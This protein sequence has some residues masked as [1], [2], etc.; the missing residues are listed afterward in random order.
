MAVTATFTNAAVA[1]EILTFTMT[2]V[3]LPRITPTVRG[4]EEVY[5]ELTGKAYA[6][7]ANTNAE[8]ATTLLCCSQNKSVL[9]AQIVETQGFDRAT[10]V[11]LEQLRTAA[12]RLPADY[13]SRLGSLSLYQS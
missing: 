2:K 9:A 3:A 7:L 1:T 6:D 8:L 11:P 5:L 4:R 10:V 13:D 12:R